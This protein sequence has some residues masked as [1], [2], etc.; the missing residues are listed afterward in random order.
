MNTPKPLLLLLASSFLFLSCASAGTSSEKKSDPAE[1]NPGPTSDET[2]RKREAKNE[3]L[4]SDEPKPDP[5]NPGEI[6]LAAINV[7]RRA[8]GIFLYKYKETMDSIVPDKDYET[9]RRITNPQVIADLKAA[10]SDNAGY[11]QQYV[12]RCLPVW[13]Y[14]L[15]F[16]DGEKKKTF[17]FS[18]RCNTMKLVEDRLFRD[19]SPQRAVLYPLFNFEINEKTSVEGKK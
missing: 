18:F 5:K 1:Q 12:S 2:P 6:S 7:V 16:R 9:V 10:L 19:F 13:D 3:E 4:K 14:G 15:E 8:N 11:K 17:L